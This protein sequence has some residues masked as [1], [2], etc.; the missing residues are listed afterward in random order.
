MNIDVI[1]R[2]FNRQRVR[3]LLIG[4]VN[5]LI[6]HEP[7]ITYDIDLWIEDSPPNRRRC[8]HALAKLGAEWGASVQDWRPVKR[9]PT[10]WLAR[11]SVYCLTS[12]HGAIDVFRKVKG[13]R[14]WRSSRNRAVRGTTGAGVAFWG[15]SDADMLRCQKALSRSERKGERVRSLER[16]ARRRRKSK[17]D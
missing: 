12:P 16:T 9:L 2:A 15:L 10:G 11:Q 5:Y 4:G 17:R 6:R 14:E 3:H 8:E 7:I 13:L 1:L